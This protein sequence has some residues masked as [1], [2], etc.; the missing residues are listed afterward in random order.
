[1]FRLCVSTLSN[2]WGRKFSGPT[3]NKQ[4]MLLVSRGGGCAVQAV[5]FCVAQFCG[6]L[7]GVTS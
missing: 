1:M 7:H 5:R 2:G 4:D 6:D 3:Y